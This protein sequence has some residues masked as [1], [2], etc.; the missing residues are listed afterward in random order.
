MLF[1]SP[2]RNSKILIFMHV[3]EAVQNVLIQSMCPH[4][5]ARGLFQLRAEDVFWVPL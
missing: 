4:N 3:L 2:V 1:F 5:P